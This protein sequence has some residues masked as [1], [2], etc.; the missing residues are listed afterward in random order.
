MVDFR[1]G[2]Y[3]GVRSG[4]CDKSLIAFKQGAQNSP[5]RLPS[6]VI[7]AVRNV[8]PIRPVSGWSDADTY[9]STVLQVERLRLT[10]YTDR[11][12][13]GVCGRS[14]IICNGRIVPE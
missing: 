5:F 11:L 12:S 14:G 3:Q 8:N 6:C 4:D 1:L 13:M 2:E 10:R 9:R 7:K